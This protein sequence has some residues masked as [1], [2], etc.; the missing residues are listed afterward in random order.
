MDVTPLSLAR[1]HFLASLGF[2]ALFLAIALALAWVLLLFKIQARRTGA[3]GWTA[4]YRL[5]VRLF[6]LAFVLA[7]AAC[8][9]L[10]FQLG[11]LWPILMERVGNVLGPL[12][13]FAVVT[14][15]VLKSCFLGVMLFGQRRVSDLAHTL[16][17]GMVAAGL[18]LAT[19]WLA[20]MVSWTHAPAGAVLVD[21]RYVLLDWVEAVF[22]PA[23]PWLFASLVLASALTG[24]FLLVGVSAW[25][26]LQRP[27]ADAERMAFR[28]GL[29]LAGVALA[30]QVAAATGAA[31]WIAQA[32]PAKAAAAAGYWHGGETARWVLFGWPDAAGQRNRAEMALGRLP[33]WWLGRSAEGGQLG[34]DAYSGMLPPVAATFWSFRI[35]V[36]A[37]LAMIVL[38]GLT[39]LR[40]HRRRLDP[41]GLP[42]A[43]LHGLSAGTWLGGLALLAGWGYMELGRQPYAVYATVTVT[44]AAG[45]IPAG[46]LAGSLAAHLALYGLLFAAFVRMTYHA[47]RYG[48]VPVRK[49][50]ARP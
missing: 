15:F 19:F 39:L 9:P 36:L 20:A 16:S 24:A 26:A 35:M 7:L 13:G 48:V 44:E 14:V 50:G 12:L 31:Q 33:D 37:G 3:P 4:A 11:A 1:V 18:L 27:P 41:A 40:L 46:L 17:V 28:V 32:Q 45:D 23:M 6:A 47:A 49:A 29:R 25:Q 30:L 42:R 10:L 34:L 21:G 5:W 8:V 22:N 2:F 38:A 43:W